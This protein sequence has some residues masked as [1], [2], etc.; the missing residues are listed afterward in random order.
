MTEATRPPPS[1]H[2]NMGSKTATTPPGHQELPPP[3]TTRASLSSGGPVQSNAQ[4]TPSSS[5]Q[6]IESRSRKRPAAEHHTTRA[7]RPRRARSVRFLLSDDGEDSAGDD[8]P[9]YPSSSSSSSS[10]AWS[11]SAQPSPYRHVVSSP[12][13]PRYHSTSSHCTTRRPRFFLN[14]PRGLPAQQG[15]FFRTWHPMPGE[16]LPN[17]QDMFPRVNMTY[18]TFEEL[19]AEYLRLLG[20]RFTNNLQRRRDAR[21]L[22]LCLAQAMKIMFREVAIPPTEQEQHADPVRSDF[23]LEAIRRRRLLGHADATTPDD[24]PQRH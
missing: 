14:D 3:T 17:D 16:S 20:G 15:Y 9:S 19:I 23:E 24:S 8:T 13:L 7:K 2:P 12:E 22:G 1:S 10:T 5:F 11:A 4:P 21:G 18:D 6:P